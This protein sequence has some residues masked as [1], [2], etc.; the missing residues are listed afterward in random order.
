[1]SDCS[2]NKLFLCLPNAGKEW[3][4]FTFV[5]LH[6]YELQLQLGQYRFL[7]S[8]SKPLIYMFIILY[9]IYI[10]IYIIYNI[11]NIYIRGLEE[12]RKKRY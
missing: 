6:N 10:I 4:L 5:N 1:M 9:I 8:S 11:I 3:I 7:R 2:G 12:E